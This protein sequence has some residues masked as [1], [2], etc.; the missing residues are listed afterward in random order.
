MNDFPNQSHN[1]IALIE[2]TSYLAHLVRTHFTYACVGWS[3]EDATKLLINSIHDLAHNSQNQNELLRL[4]KL[5]N[6]LTSALEM[7]DN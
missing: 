2:D 6:K 1:S 7:E 4:R 5:A 3:A